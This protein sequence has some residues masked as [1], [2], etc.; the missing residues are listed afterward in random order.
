MFTAFAQIEETILKKEKKKTI[1]LAGAQDCDALAAVVNARRR[2]IAKVI[3]IGDVEKTK[4]LLAGMEEPAEHYEF[5]SCEGENPCARLACELVKEGRADIPMKGLMQTASFMRAILDK[6]TFDF[7]PEKGILSQTTVLEFE[8]RLMQITDC[9][10]NIQPDYT[11]KMKI[12]T[13][14]GALARKLGI[15]NPRVAVLAPAELVNP[16]MQS[17]VDAAMLSKAAE[18]GQLKGMIVDG[19]LAMDNSLSEEAAKHKGIKS[20]VAGHADILLVPD[21]CT[22]NVLTK[23]L[24]HFAKGIPSAGLLIG[25]NVPVVM[26]SRTD[27]P[28]NK[29]NAIL[30]S[31][32]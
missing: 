15:E 30:M 8:G 6:E 26:T 13:N 18:R 19:P 31:C 7:V 27:L 24:V 12:L 29:Y 22:G 10:V 17:T 3:L 2:G 9:A 20:E 14:A 25:T 23:A 21:L 28:E 5:I 32:L 4:E 11:D 1:A 16:K